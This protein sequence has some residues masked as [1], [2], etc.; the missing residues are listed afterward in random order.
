MHVSRLA[1]WI[2]MKTSYKSSGPFLHLLGLQI[3][4][5]TVIFV[6]MFR[7]LPAS[8]DTNLF[9]AGFIFDLWRIGD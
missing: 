9:L 3:S 2:V 4:F 5:S 6:Y 8:R 1:K 7:I